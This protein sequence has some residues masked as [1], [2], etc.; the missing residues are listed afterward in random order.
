MMP[1]RTSLFDMA[2]IEIAVT[3]RHTRLFV[4]GGWSFRATGVAATGKYWSSGVC[5]SGS[6]RRGCRR[7]KRG[8]KASSDTIHPRTKQHTTGNGCSFAT[9]ARLLCTAWWLA[10]IVA[11][12][13]IVGECRGNFHRFRAMLHRSYISRFAPIREKNGGNGGTQSAHTPP[14]A[15]AVVVVACASL[16]HSWYRSMT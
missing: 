5:V 10:K 7:R 9:C 8:P 13:E 12:V 1:V 11:I 4:A 16:P 6:S 2:T 14:A 3:D 15:A